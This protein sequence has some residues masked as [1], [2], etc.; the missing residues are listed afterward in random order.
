MADREKVIKEWENVL[1]GDPSDTTWNLI[2]DTIE[3]LKEQEAVTP[4]YEPTTLSW[5]CGKCGQSFD[6]CK[7]K[8][9]P[10]CGKAVKWE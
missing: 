2:D 1:S 4:D 7:Y 9:C 6:R 3:L 5:S 10:V 8:Y